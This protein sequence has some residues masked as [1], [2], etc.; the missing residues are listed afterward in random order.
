[1]P[2]AGACPG[3]RTEDERLT[4]RFRDADEV[5]GLPGIGA[6]EPSWE[7]AIE[8][9]EHETAGERGAGL[10]GRLEDMEMVEKRWI[11]DGRRVEGYLVVSNSD[12][13]WSLGA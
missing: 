1:M 3:A 4:R 10:V 11:Q 12:A 9:L 13:E 7:K 5:E 2:W 8:P 6:V